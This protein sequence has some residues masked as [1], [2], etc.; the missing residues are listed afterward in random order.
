[1]RT[2]HG[3]NRHR[4]LLL[5]LDWLAHSERQQ[6]GVRAIKHSIVAYWIDMIAGKEDH[7]PALNDKLVETLAHL[8]CEC[9]NIAQRNDLVITQALLFQSFPGYGLRIK[10]RPPQD[11]TRLQRMQQVKNFAVK[12]RRTWVAIYQ[13]DVHWCHRT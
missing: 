5:A 8:R 13:Q 12:Q 6:E 11:A 9:F 2:L 3:G 7:P 10:Q 1:M 4:L